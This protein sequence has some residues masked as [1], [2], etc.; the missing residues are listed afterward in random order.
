MNELKPCPFCG[1]IPFIYKRSKH[2]KFPYVVK[3]SGLTCGCRTECWNNVKGAVNSWNRRVD[4]DG[5]P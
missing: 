1:S 3:C 4:K 2:K 5:E